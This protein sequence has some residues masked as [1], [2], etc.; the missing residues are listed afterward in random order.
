MCFAPKVQ[1]IDNDVVPDASAVADTAIAAESATPQTSKKNTL[2][3]SSLTID[4]NPTQSGTG[5]NL[6]I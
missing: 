3:R 4:I 2:G 1:K 6:P 5:L